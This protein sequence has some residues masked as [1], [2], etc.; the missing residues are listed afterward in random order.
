MEPAIPPIILTAILAVILIP[1]AIQEA[2]LIPAAIPT[3]EA[4]RIPLAT[5][6]PTHRAVQEVQAE[7][8]QVVQEALAAQEDQEE[9]EEE[10]PGS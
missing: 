8:V 3:P 4:T 7:E 5:H 6:K 9:A 2:I 10:I 1:A